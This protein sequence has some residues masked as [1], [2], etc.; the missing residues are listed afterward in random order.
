MVL[1]S[2]EGGSQHVPPITADLGFICVVSSS[3]FFWLFRD[4]AAGQLL[5]PITMSSNFFAQINRSSFATTLVHNLQIPV[6]H[7]DHGQEALFQSV[8]ELHHRLHGSSGNRCLSFEQGNIGEYI[9]RLA[10]L[11]TPV[12]SAGALG[13]RSIPASKLL[14]RF[15]P[16]QHFLF[17]V[18]LRTRL[19]CV[20]AFF[21]FGLLLHLYTRSANLRRWLNNPCWPDC[22]RKASCNCMSNWRSLG[23]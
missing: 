16:L 9:L 23:Q 7:W 2:T 6:C 10:V 17:F 22:C 5:N 4:D 15:Q 13:T 8:D 18:L 12:A 11:Y 14:H 1:T 19:V 21:V 3:D 20:H